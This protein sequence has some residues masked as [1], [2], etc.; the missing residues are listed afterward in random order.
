[1]AQMLAVVKESVEVGAVL[2]QRAIPTAAPGEVVIKVQAAAVCGTDIHIYDWNPWAQGAGINLPIVLGHECAGDVV[3]VGSGVTG[4]KPGDRVAVDTH[5]PCGHCRLCQSGRQHIC[6]NLKLFGVHSDGCFAQYARVPAVCARRLPAEIPYTTGALFE[7]L[8]TAFRGAGETRPAGKTVAVIGCGPI[9]LFAL[10]SLRALG[11]ARIIAVDISPTRLEIAEK[12][13]ADFLINPKK[14]DLV[15]ALKDLTAGYG[16]DA[17]VE[18]SGN[19]TA[20]RQAFAALMK[21]GR[22]AMIGLA[23]KPLELDSGMDIVFKEATITGI[24]GRMMFSTW[25]ALETLVASRRLQVEPVLTHRLPLRD[26]NA[27]IELARSG[28]AAKVILEPWRD[29]GG[30]EV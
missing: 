19:V 1:M 2:C 15:V 26:F 20:T 17:F 14:T 30:K 23:G 11:A 4:L 25:E 22:V 29:G 8:G 9:G 6:Q 21:G 3:A 28:K 27:G 7:P 13:G 16:V 5:I 24:H 18:A 12:L 10:A